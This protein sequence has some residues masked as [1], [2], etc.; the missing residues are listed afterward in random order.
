MCQRLDY[1][2]MWR[3]K[4]LIMEWYNFYPKLIIGC[5]FS[6]SEVHIISVLDIF[7]IENFP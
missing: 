7:H 3:E 1:L 4:S 2:V 5:Y 6:Q